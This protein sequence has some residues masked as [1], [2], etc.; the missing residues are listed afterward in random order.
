MAPDA[1]ATAAA[2]LP[3]RC[4]DY[5]TSDN[6]FYADN[7]ED[8]EDY[9]YLGMWFT[10]LI[11]YNNFVPISLYVSVEMVNYVQ[12]RR[13]TRP[14]PDTRHYIV[15]AEPEMLQKEPDEHKNDEVQRRPHSSPPS[16]LS[17][18]IRLSS[19]CPSP[20]HRPSTSTRTGTSTTR[21][22]TRRRWPA[23]RT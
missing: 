16:P 12:V 17:E 3:G 23:R 9:S 14:S 18:L 1:L 7:C 10:F 19:A 4:Y 20:P 6:S 13:H 8:S 11:L 5:S 21:T 22:R 15:I 2:L